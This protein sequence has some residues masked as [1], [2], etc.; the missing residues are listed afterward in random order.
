MKHLIAFLCLG[1]SASIFAAGPETPS[2]GLRYYYPVPAANPQQV[3]EADVCVYG[4]T[5]GG[6]SAAVQ[7]ARMGK[8]A[9]LVVMRRHVGGMTSGGLTAT[10]IG[11]RKAI[12][13]FANEV[14]ARI[15]KTSGFRPSDAERVFVELL[16]ETG[17]AVFYE[18]RL[19][20]VSK[21]GARIDAIVLENGNSVRAK[22][23]V[24]ATYEGDLLAGAGVSY[25]VGREANAIYGETIN[26][27]Q[28]RKT[29][30]FSV[31]V[32]PYVE[33]GNPASGLLP[34]I[35]AE[36]PGK[37]GAGD[38]KV[39]AY[40]FRIWLSN[41]AN[42]QAFPKPSGYDR[43]RYTL[44]ERYWKA[45]PDKLQLPSQLRNGDC[46]N[47]GGFSTDH[48]GANYAWP[49]A[50]YATREKIFQDHVNYQQ[51]L[52]WFCANDSAAP[53][54]VRAQV[55]AFGLVAGE[56][57]ETGGWPHELYVR[58]GR[59]MI[60]GYVMTEAECT[61]R[62]IVE[63]PVGLAAYT[64]DSHNC[65][66][67]VVDGAVRNEGDVQTGVPRP[68]PVSYRSIVPKESEC[69]NLFVSVCLSASHIAYGSIR[70]EPVFMILGQSAG[71]AAVLAIDSGVPVQR[72]DYAKLRERLLADQQILSWEG[73]TL[74]AATRDPGPAGG[75]EVGH[76]GAKTMG[77]WA[78]STAG[79][80]LHDG[81]A[82]KGTKTAT[83]TPNLPQEGTY[84]VYLLWTQNRNRATNVPVE[85]VTA[86]GKETLT[87]NQREK[88]GW[89]KVAT[90]RF[91]AGTAS[92]LTISN[93]ETN[94]H[95]IVDTVRWVPAK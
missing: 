84:D 40:N 47:N 77:E 18:H 21:T 71:T 92:S 8:K 72:V 39:Q 28:Y 44:L 59:R 42:R 93:K 16:R 54:A 76:Q 51:G 60:S 17:V 91:K 58:E 38:K 6:V 14:Y 88:G 57:P 83:F 48:I 66:R 41:A 34:T 30:N 80:Y 10:D 45:A 55:N 69:T 1:L 78:T 12:G 37:P 87:V 2:P 52:M 31:V 19:K 50:D 24:D 90:G 35:S 46:N 65:Q 95:V 25:H 94:G 68:Y 36:A 73:P 62:K 82:D 15:G 64:M 63:D 74:P 49:E 67:I 20:S 79:N 61:S 4:G 70:M 29:H 89:V 22:V 81:N 53:E 7:A 56:F 32:D 86:T 23:F 85:V 9:V 33:P 26:G 75:I 13:G 11:N 27:I 5:P 3:V 43:G